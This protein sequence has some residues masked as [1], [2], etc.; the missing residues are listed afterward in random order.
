MIVLAVCGTKGGVGKTSLCANL[1]GLVADWGWKV[2]LIDT[3]SQPSLSEYFPIAERAEFGVTRL[4]SHVEASRSLSRT[5]LPGLDIIVS[6]DPDGICER[7]LPTLKDGRNRIRHALYEVSQYDLV[8][9]DTKGAANAVLEASLFASDQILSPI[10]PDILSTSEFLRG[11]MGSFSRLRKSLALNCHSISGVF[12]RTRRTVDAAT[13]TQ[14]MRA[15]YDD[16]VI[17][18]LL[19]TAVPDRAV[20][21][22]AATAQIPVHR[23][24]KKRSG[25][26]SANETM[27]ALAHELLPMFSPAK[28][29]RPLALGK[30]EE[31]C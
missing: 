3:D 20:Y 11:T 25:G 5:V 28:N 6:D 9:I 15:L 23:F 8:I 24:E 1:G 14:Q 12:Y 21:R 26:C 10:V 30:S 16:S 18:K 19:S 27:T 7:T 22:D 29:C 17:L 13:I 4:L 31:P 2:L